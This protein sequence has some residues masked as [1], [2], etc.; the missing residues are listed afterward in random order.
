MVT[1]R[2]C[3]NEKS[4]TPPL[5]MKSTLTALTVEVRSFGRFRSGSDWLK[6]T[7]VEVSPL[8]AA[9]P[10][11]AAA[12][13]GT[14][15]IEMPCWVT[16]TSGTSA[17]AESEQPPAD[18]ASRAANATA[19]K[20]REPMDDDEFFMTDL[21]LSPDVEDETQLRGRRHD[22]N[23]RV[24]TERHGRVRAAGAAG[25]LLVDVV[26]GGADVAHPAVQE[27][28]DPARAEVQA[29]VGVD[30]IVADR[31]QDR[32]VGEAGAG[33]AAR[34]AVRVPVEVVAGLEGAGGARAE[35][36]QGDAGP[37]ALADHVVAEPGLAAHE[38]I[39]AEH[40][41]PSG[42]VGDAGAHHQP[43]QG[44]GTLDLL[45]EGGRRALNRQLLV[46]LA[47][48]GGLRRSAAQ[49]RRDEGHPR[50]RVLAHEN[51]IAGFLRI[52]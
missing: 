6:L 12:L 30:V 36:Q 9:E 11:K 43:Q 37:H 15:G 23:R 42:P 52:L 7:F 5:A 29:Q 32:A 28:H 41:R 27:E 38:R 19:R 33:D 48:D 2:P 44:E 14:P 3:R 49:Q 4:L 25:D 34:D 8:L 18:D 17:C 50:E 31:L 26:D 16:S 21:D 13:A 45:L 40:R 39:R 20:P 51:V 1:R 24:R 46:G 47:G 35:R 10:R 22:P